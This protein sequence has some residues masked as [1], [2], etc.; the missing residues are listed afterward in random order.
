MK[1][2]SKLKLN[3]LN[4]VELDEQEMEILKGGAGCCCSC[5]AA[6]SGGSSTSDNDSANTAGGL[7]SIYGCDGGGAG[8]TNEPKVRLMS[9]GFC[10]C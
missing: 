4:K 8:D 6:G 9:T 7:S 2:L 10:A 1:K 3:N 5:W